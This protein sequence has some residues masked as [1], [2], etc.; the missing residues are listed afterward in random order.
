LPD[1]QQIG[2]LFLIDMRE[3]GVRNVHFNPDKDNVS[4]AWNFIGRTRW[5]LASLDVNNQQLAA[6][7]R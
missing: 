7:S 3:G 1:L 2:Y 5:A 6:Y 4:T